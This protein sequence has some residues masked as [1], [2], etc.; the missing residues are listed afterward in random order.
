MLK[1]NKKCYTKLVKAVAIDYYRIVHAVLPLQMA[2]GNQFP[3]SIS[4]VYG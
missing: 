2:V 1:N 3:E 4:M